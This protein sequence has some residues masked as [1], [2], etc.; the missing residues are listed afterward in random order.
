MGMRAENAVQIGIMEFFSEHVNCIRAVQAKGGLLQEP[1]PQPFKPDSSVK[2][3]RV[4]KDPNHLSV[5]PEAR[6]RRYR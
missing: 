5:C 3:T 2:L 1:I 4:P 6:V